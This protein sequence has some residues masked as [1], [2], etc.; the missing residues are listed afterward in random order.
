M[1]I[2][3]TPGIVAIL[4]LLTLSACGGVR[5]PT[6][7]SSVSNT[8]EQAIQAI[9]EKNPPNSAE[10]SAL[11]ADANT[12][13]ASWSI[14]RAVARA[15][16]TGK[17]ISVCE[18][19]V[20]KAAISMA[21]DQRTVQRRQIA[22]AHERAQVINYRYQREAIECMPQHA[23]YAVGLHYYYFKSSPPRSKIPWKPYH[24]ESTAEPISK[25]VQ[26]AKFKFLAFNDIPPEYFAARDQS[27]ICLT[28]VA[29]HYGRTADEIVRF[30]GGNAKKLNSTADANVTHDRKNSPSTMVNSAVSL[31]TKQAKTETLSS[32]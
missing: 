32:S 11:R 27:L 1:K 15:Q 5:P 16:C 13:P 30:V 18:R 2:S 21:R 28:R 26:N 10:C 14:S 7:E 3:N 24:F 8:F 31:F 29:E 12:M 19:I 22:R 20:R 23:A 6:Q 25:L 9:C 17:T 4:I